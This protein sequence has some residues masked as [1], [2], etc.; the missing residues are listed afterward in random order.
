MNHDKF[1]IAY[2]KLRGWAEIEGPE[3][4]YDGPCEW[5]MILVPGGHLPTGYEFPPRGKI[6]YGLFLSSEPNPADNIAAA[7]KLLE[8]LTRAVEDVE[9]ARNCHESV[10]RVSWGDTVQQRAGGGSDD[11]ITVAICLAWYQWKTGQ[12]WTDEIEV[13]A[14]GTG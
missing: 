3:Y 9:I 14:N 2:Y 5:G 4:D 8:E 6:A 10:W 7:W 11:S 13:K 1:K 12:E